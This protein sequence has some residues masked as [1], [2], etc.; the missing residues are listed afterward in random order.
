MET[1]NDIVRKVAEEM[2][3]TSMQDITAEIIN[4]W[5]VRIGDAA[6]CEKSSQVGNEP[7]TLDEAIAHAEEAVND[8]PCGQEHKQLADWLKELRAIKVGNAAQMREALQSVLGIVNVYN[9]KFIKNNVPRICDA[10]LSTPA[11]N[12]DLYATEP[13]AYQ[14]YLTSMKNET[15]ENYMYFEPWLF[16]VA[17]GAK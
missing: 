7:M 16:A 14:A 8:T 15:K 11:R 4:K 17:K 12:C 6:A 1:I 5:A 9:Y 10:A 2:L 13:E 3:N